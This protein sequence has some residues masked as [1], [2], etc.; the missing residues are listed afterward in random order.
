MRNFGRRVVLNIFTVL[1]APML[2]MYLTQR[3]VSSTSRQR[4]AALRRLITRNY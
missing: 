2:L 3:N 4:I 1:V